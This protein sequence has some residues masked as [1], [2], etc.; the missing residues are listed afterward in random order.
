MTD[1]KVLIFMLSGMMLL[2]FTCLPAYGA[3]PGKVPEP[4]YESRLDKG[5]FNT[6]P[7]SYLLINKAHEDKS[8][9]REFLESAKI[10]SPD[11]PAVYFELSKESISLSATGIFECIDYFVQGI[12]AYCRSFWW[13]FSFA[14]VMYTSLILSLILSLVTVLAIRIPLDAGLFL[15]DV[16][17]DKKRLTLAG[18]VVLLSLFGPVGS[19]TGVFILISSNIMGKNRIVL[20][21]SM[22]FFF[23]SPLLL[24]L[25]GV[26][27]SSPSPALRSI[28][29]VNE[30]KDNRYAIE[31]LKME[32]GFDSLF[33]YALALKREGYYK[34]AEEIYKGIITR[35]AEIDPRVYVNLGNV[36]YSAG[37]PKAAEESYKKSIDIKP[38]PSALYNL[39]QMSRE[40]LDFV[41]G[42]EYF[43]EATRLDPASV[44]RYAA[45]AG[46]GPNRLIVD[47]TLH[48]P[49]IWEYAINK[50]AIFSSSSWLLNIVLNGI[51]L[52]ICY[53]FS[54]R[55]KSHAKRC[56][57][58]G[59]VF[60]DNC[61]EAKTRH[62]TCPRCYAS[63]VRI[64]RLNLKER[65]ATF[66]LVQKRQAA[67]IRLARMLSYF[68]PGAGHIYAGEMLSGF[69]LL[70]P[71]LFS[72]T[73]L[74]MQRL[75]FPG[76][77]PFT[78][79]LVVPVMVT[80]LG[81]V[82][83][84]SVFHMRKGINKGWL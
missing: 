1:K 44:S 58:C 46:Q 13:G 15:H 2:I 64:D 23:L 27:L 84:L 77:A 52:T 39:S 30:G 8:R 42:E 47:E 10:Y 28:A 12:K 7:Y 3:A 56:R 6:E 78:H 63:L 5:I 61:S 53:L 25:I 43:N 54:N 50:A 11:L 41:K 36:Y 37:N 45:L 35:S 24:G 34:D 17:E 69:I 81:I 76:L 57:R 31:N 75:S 16:T 22:L 48:E 29:A 38:L 65:M 66:L 82:Y 21:I 70:W 18:I 83:F 79:G 68:V 73:V 55:M 60:C 9:A 20:Y 80:V 19:I 74:V 40:R 62:D 26:F 71:F 67:K 33:S 32:T 4:L 49:D 51:V 72:V 59:A 14:G